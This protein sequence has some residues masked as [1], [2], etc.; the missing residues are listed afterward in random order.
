MPRRAVL[1]I[2]ERSSLT[3]LPESQEEIFRYYTLSEQDISII[4]QHPG[5]PNYLGFAVH[6]CYMRYP[7]I[8]IGVGEFPF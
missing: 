7:G 1:S 2:A 4:H 5:A 3:A 6:L 8:T